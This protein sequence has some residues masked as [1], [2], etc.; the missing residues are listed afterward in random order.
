MYH[1][2]AYPY[3]NV[4]SAH[5]ITLYV[6]VYVCMYAHT[7]DYLCA[8]VCVC[9]R[10]MYVCGHAMYV[11]CEYVCMCVFMHVCDLFIRTMSSISTFEVCALSE[12]CFWTKLFLC[13]GGTFAGYI[14][15]C[16]L[17]VHVCMHV[18]MY[19]HIVHMGMCVCVLCTYF[20]IYVCMYV[21]VYVGMCIFMHSCM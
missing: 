14:F 7:H 17:C 19:V 13:N 4:I 21:P 18:R 12:F 16:T 6:C 1:V 11:M 8:Y 15:C 10:A 5:M 2:C 20:C 3:M 9:A